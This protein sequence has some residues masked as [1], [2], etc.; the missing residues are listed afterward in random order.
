MKDL[1]YNQ[2]Q[3]QVISRCQMR[4]GLVGVASV[5]VSLLLAADTDEE[6]IGTY[7][8]VDGLHLQVF[9]LSLS[10][11]SNVCFFFHHLHFHHI[12]LSCLLHISRPLFPVRQ[13][14]SQDVAC[15]LIN[16]ASPSMICKTQILNPQ[17]TATQRFS[18]LNVILPALTISAFCHILFNVFSSPHSFQC[19]Q[20]YK[21][22]LMNKP[23]SVKVSAQFATSLDFVAFL[24]APGVRGHGERYC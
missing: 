19:T 10:S 9:L 4:H 13:Y 22:Q 7:R 5:M 23:L 16:T 24:A 12:P 3:V 18:P 14:V 21:A 11:S 1:K 8:N 20:L 2:D 17:C 15:P 6:G